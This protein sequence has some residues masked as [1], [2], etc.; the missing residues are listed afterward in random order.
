MMK[1][2]FLKTLALLFAS[3]LF[4]SAF[5]GCGT[6]TTSG[7]DSVGT[8]ADSLESTEHTHTLKEIPAA[9]ARCEKDGNIRYWECEGCGKL[10]SD[11]SGTTEISLEDT[12]IPAAHSP[13]FVEAFTADEMFESDAIAYY[14]CS[15]CGKDFSDEACTAELQPKDIYEQ[16]TFLLSPA[17]VSV[18]ETTS[19]VYATVNENNY[20]LAVKETHFA[21]R[22]FLG[23][24]IGDADFATLIDEM[25]DDHL[26]FRLNLNIDTEGTLSDSQWYHFKF[27]YDAE[28]AFGGFSDSDAFVHFNLLPEGGD[29]I[30]AAFLENGGSYVTLVRDESWMIAYIEDLEGNLFELARTN[31]FG[32][33]PM[34]RI[35]LGVNQG[36]VADPL[37]PATAKDGKLV[38][39]TTDPCQPQ[40][41][42]ENPGDIIDEPPQ[43]VIPELSIGDPYDP[44]EKLWNQEAAYA[45]EKQEDGSTKI[46]W[47]DG[48]GAWAKIWQ[49]VSDWSAEEGEYLK[50]ALTLERATDVYILYVKDT[51]GA[52]ETQMYRADLAAGEHTLYI[53]LYADAG[54][55]FLIEYYFAANEEAAGVKAGSVTIS[56]V[57]F[58]DGMPLTLGAVYDVNAT[59]G[60]PPQYA[61]AETEDGVTVVSWNDGRDTWAKAQQDVS[62]YDVSKG[63]YLKIV[64]TADQTTKFGVYIGDTALMEHTE[65]AQGT[66]TVYLEIPENTGTAFSLIYYFDAGVN[67][68]KAG[69]VSFA[70]ISI[71]A[72]KPAA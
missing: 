2:G 69:T 27:G 55:D 65:F 52:G 15:V 9:A 14:H 16:K 39:G 5:A 68:V 67:P 66:H 59:L 18:P 17:Q 36:F 71:V 12:V 51:T 3:A 20:T 29:A 19:R 53:P 63:K 26:E 31:C 57:S 49:D 34:A 11:A 62:G 64:F 45:V 33:T 7:S 38:I 41:S 58:T 50:I 60:Q 48:R 44:G 37:Y 54:S 23:W 8:S 40:T 35:S 4:A 56:E 61:I 21:L 25:A 47:T 46:S 30:E 32:D 43:P 28:G 72:E 42:E 10:F 22:I 70:E 6:G 24:E 13:E 1:K